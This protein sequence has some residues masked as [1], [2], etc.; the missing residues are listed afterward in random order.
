MVIKGYGVGVTA[1]PAAQK[2]RLDDF[3]ETAKFRDGICVFAQ[4]DAQ[5]SD[6]AN[7]KVAADRAQ[8]VRQYL[9]AKGVPNDV[10]EVADQEKAFTFFGL[11]PQDQDDDRRVM[12]THN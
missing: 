1:I 6:A 12:V 10:I 5:G 4:V 3:A 9:I 7:Q 8:R 11:L 2:Q